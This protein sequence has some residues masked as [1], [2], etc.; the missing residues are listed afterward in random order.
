M[1]FCPHC[2]RLNPGHPRICHYCG[3]TWYVR[4][5]PR[6]H[7]NP[8]NAQYCG[9]CGSAD[10]TETGGQIPWFSIALKGFLWLL[11]GLMIYCLVVGFWNVLKSSEAASF[12]SLII[13][14]CLLVL[15]FQFCL[16][17]MPSPVSRTVRRVG[18]VF[19]GSILR[20]LK[21]IW[22]IMK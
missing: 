1:R 7:E 13:I 6:G 2:H 21:A 12:F 9:T 18:K 4:L 22:E 14:L 5:C 8:Y 19:S 15:G 17:L 10:L 3:R 16:S 20:V 11:S